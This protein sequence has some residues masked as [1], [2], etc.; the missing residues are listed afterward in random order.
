MTGFGVAERTWDERG[1]RVSVELRSVNARFLELKLRQPFGVAVEHRLRKRLEHSLG[2]GRVELSLRVEGGPDSGRDPL[3]TLGVTPSQIEGTLAALGSLA[4]EADRVGVE[5]P[6]PNS[7]EL[8][9]FLQSGGIAA[10]ARGRDM[11]E[12]P[13]FLDELVAEALTMLSHMRVTEGAALAGVLAALYDEL[14]TQVATVERSLEGEGPRLLDAL[15]SRVQELLDRVGR[16]T[17]EGA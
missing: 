2:R 1:Q 7:L 5:L 11:S 13:P 8:L 14:E 6:P 16:A 3:A 17:V 12:T 15:E 10:G 4:A 9:R